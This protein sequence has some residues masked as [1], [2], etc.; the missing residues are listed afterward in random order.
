[1]VMA[2]K[3]NK[4]SN[5]WLALMTTSVGTLMASI[6][7]SIVNIANPVM[8]AEFGVS[9]AQ[10]QWVAT[11]YLIVTS[12]MTVFFGRMGGR[13]GAHRMYIFGV[14]A[15]T[16]G[17]LACSLVDQLQFLLMTRAIQGLGA[18]MMVSVSIGLVATIFPQAERGR[19]MGINALMVG[20]GSVTGPTVGGLVLSVGSWHSIFLLGVPFGLTTLVFALLWLR[21]PLPRNKEISLGLGSAL[22][23]MAAIACLVMFLNGGFDGQQWFGLAC[24]ILV[25]GFI[26]VERRSAQPLLAPALL[27][28]KRFILGN[29]IAILSYAAQMMMTF[30]IPFF[31]ETIWAIPVGN[32][33]FLMMASA[34]TMA[35]SGPLSGIVAD[36]FGAFKVMIPALISVGLGLTIAFFLGP[37]PIIW[38][39]IIM[40]V[41]MGAGMGFFNTPNNS[42]IM[43]AAGRENSSF[44]SGFVGTCRTLAFCIGTALSASIFQWATSISADFSSVTGIMLATPVDLHRFSFTV[45]LVFAITLVFASLGL[46][47]YLVLTS[48][49]KIETIPIDLRREES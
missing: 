16:L 13:L 10:I 25:I 47:I 17:S 30:Q 43:T 35:I 24:I 9:M 39:F 37:V 4:A 11:I 27:K 40:M 41:L 46:C 8:A 1:M 42:D 28:N 49:K 23:L 2:L 5:K 19:A 22:L 48:K 12:S 20:L 21:S 34:L 29:I 6:N 44:A 3:S 26:F 14:A 38:L 15:F 33:G 45:V 18:A 36:R 7:N 32:V 31:L